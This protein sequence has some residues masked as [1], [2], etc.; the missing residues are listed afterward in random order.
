MA[1]FFQNGVITTLQRLVD[2]P[3][4]GLEEE[5]KGLTTTRRTVLLPPALYSEF[6]GA[7]ITTEN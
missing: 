5:L 4:K 6:E 2:R 7:A 1:D 3:E